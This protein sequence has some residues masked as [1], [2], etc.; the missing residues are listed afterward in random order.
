MIPTLYI[1]ATVRNVALLD[2]ALLVFKTVRTGFPTANIHVLGNGLEVFAAQ[3]LHRAS[4]SV[5]ASFANDRRV[6]HDVWI[7]SL[8]GA[9]SGPFWICDTDVVFFESV[10]RW[11]GPRDKTVVAGR[12]EPEFSEEW[13]ESRHVERLHTALMWLNGPLVRQA[14]RTWMG[15]F[16]AFLHNAQMNLIRQQFVPVAGAEPLFYDTCAGLWHAFG[17]TIFDDRQNEAFEHLHCATY[18]DLVKTANLKDLAQVHKSIFETPS[19]ARGMQREQAKY[20]Q[21]RAYPLGST[22]VI[23][24]K[25]PAHALQSPSLKPG[26]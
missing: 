3:E 10:E 18:S 14:T 24:E 9:A 26:R 8:V 11:F 12:F 16:P 22:L 15:R 7:E 25:G 4:L 2:A 6:S 5:G 17:G 1:L 20:Y 19:L 23:P 21:S 13:T